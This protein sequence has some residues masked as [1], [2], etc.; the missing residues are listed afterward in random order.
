M[1]AVSLDG[2]AYAAEI[3]TEVTRRVAW[4]NAHHG[5]IRL[6]AV[7]VGSDA[8]GRLYAE[9]QRKLSTKV[10]VEYELVEL[11]ERTT[12]AELSATID[13]LNADPAVTGIILQLPVPKHI[14]PALAQY[15]IDPY[16]DIEGVN[17]ANIGWLFYGEPIIAPCTALAVTEL[18]RRSGV[19]VRGAHAVVVGQSRIV[20]RPVTMFLLTQEAT[21]T[22][23]HIATR[24]LAS[25]TRQADILV[26]AIGQPRAIGPDYVKP[27]AVV[28]DVGIN[29]ITET[30]P[31]GQPVRRTVGDVDFDAVAP[32]ASAISP[33]PGG[34]GPLTVAMLLRNT[35]EAA[36]K[37]QSRRW[38]A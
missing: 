30:G 7:L 36:V 20:G 37:Q 22:G 34:V 12:Q 6:C 5:A 1:P 28:I 19:V 31:G 13:R 17:P 4:Y 16:K 2:A 15:R 21:V 24:D 23:C 18:I 38:T 9:S 35:V 25:H 11:P 29:R 8:A 27:G 14:D 3:R 32:L 10:G 33:V 26:V